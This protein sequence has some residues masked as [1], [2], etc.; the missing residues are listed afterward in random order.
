MA[1]PLELSYNW[2]TPV[3]VATI[4]LVLCVALLARSRVDGWPSVAV[5]LVLSW[6]IFL[7]VVWLRTR[8]YLMVDGPILRV[9]HFRHFHDLDGRSV[10]RVAQFL[11]P[12][13]PS[14]KVTVVGRGGCTARYVVPSA[15]LR[16]GHSTLFEWLL[17]W[18][19][20]AELDKGSRKTMEQLR[21]RGLI[22]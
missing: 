19:P 22:T 3:S 20:D 5:I 9:R 8:A 7:A 10:R 18:A 12:S 2:R 16:Q 4:G 14:Y 15:L 1:H 6:L 17:A 11:T 13:G 21:I